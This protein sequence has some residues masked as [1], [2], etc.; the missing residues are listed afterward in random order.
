MEQSWE[1]RLKDVYELMRDM[2]M[3][4]DPQD[5]VRAYG[6]RVGKIIDMDR[7]LSLSRRGLSAPAFYITRDSAIESTVN[8]WKE[9]DRLTLLRGGLLAELIYSGRPVIIDDLHVPPD[10]PAI[11]VLKDFRSLAVIPMLDRGESLN[12]IVIMKKAPA[13]FDR[14]QFPEMVW[15][16]NLFGR[17]THNLVLRE[18]VRT[19]YE[20][21]DRELKVV[22]AIQRALL[23]KSAPRIETLELAADY[24]TSQR[25]G[26]DYYDFFPMPDGRWG[27]LVADVSGHGTPAAVMMAITHSIAHL[28]P[29]DTGHP[30]EL[31]AF[32][33]RHL[34]ERYTSGIEAFVTAFYGV[35]N[36][37]TRELTY[38]CAGHNPPRW[39]K[40]S[41]GRTRSIDSRSGPPMG[42][43]A[44]SVYLDL[45]IT[46]SPGDRIVFY[47]D[48][49]SEA[50]NPT[51]E[52][53]GV[54]RID[55]ALSEASD[56]DAATIRD[57]LL[58]RLGEFTAGTPALD[59]QTLV[60]ASAV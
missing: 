25:A 60:V 35:Y 5:M 7:R 14:E 55:A 51:G 40:R 2:S 12:M 22:G 42:I 32:V 56:L 11:D 33:N 6:E 39:W 24:R 44:D 34:S 43:D 47:T 26:G 15:I 16:S 13:G 27:I 52:M 57:R 54:S 58:S 45:T 46:L 49:I 20:T 41:E 31:L 29:N 28:F 23:P 4:T 18:E 59:D 1:E 17:A 19:A 53:F 30:G 48:G 3:R 50:V 37:A 38:A 9:K 21:V 10:D 36:P 8:P